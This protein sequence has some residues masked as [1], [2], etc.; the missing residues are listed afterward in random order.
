MSVHIIKSIFVSKIATKLTKRQTFVSMT[1]VANKS[2]TNHTMIII[3]LQLDIVHK[4]RERIGNT[5][6][7]Y[8]WIESKIICISVFWRNFSDNIK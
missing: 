4:E 5:I 8:L 1:G 7:T 2:D 6:T 3:F